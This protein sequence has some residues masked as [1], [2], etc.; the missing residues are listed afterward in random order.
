MAHTNDGDQRNA[1]QKD[2]EAQK[3]NRYEAGKE[4]SHLSN[5]SKDGR[6][7]ANRL[8]S[9]L[10]KNEDEVH[11][12]D[13]NIPDKDQNPTDLAKAHGNKP[14]RGAMIDEQI[15]LEEEAEVSFSWFL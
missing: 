14:S 15:K 8:E 3:P 1:S 6:S 5:D 11:N 12:S 9:E 7:I 4:G 13:P 2:S 10:R